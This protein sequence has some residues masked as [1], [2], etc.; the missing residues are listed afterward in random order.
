MHAQFATATAATDGDE[1]LPEVELQELDV[2]GHYLLDGIPVQ[3]RI[4]CGPETAYGQAVDWGEWL[5]RS[6][7]ITWEEF[8]ELVAKQ[9]PPDLGHRR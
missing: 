7:R 3:L 1:S 6:E 9:T 2:V 4:G 8:D 5:Y